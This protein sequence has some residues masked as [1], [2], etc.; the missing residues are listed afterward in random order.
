[1]TTTQ[2]NTKETTKNTPPKKG[3]WDAQKGKITNLEALRSAEKLTRKFPASEFIPFAKNTSWEEIATKIQPDK[4]GPWA[5]PIVVTTSRHVTTIGVENLIRKASEFL[6]HYNELPDYEIEI[7][8]I[9]AGVDDNKL[10][11][12]TLFR[13]YK[14]D[15]HIKQIFKYLG[16]DQFQ[17]QPIIQSPK[18]KGKFTKISFNSKKMLLLKLPL[19][20]HS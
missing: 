8:S 10:A 18:N 5:T 14:K 16:E 7:L 20:N 19:I 13:S 15:I 12:T 6:L 17:N 1:M 3:K 9:T 4:N 11:L 2:D